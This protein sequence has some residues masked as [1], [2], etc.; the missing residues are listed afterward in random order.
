MSG[1]S[2]EI[3]VVGAG[4]VGLSTAYALVEQGV[5]IRLFEAARPGAGQSAGR[6]R[7]FRHVHRRSELVRRAAESRA[8]WEEWQKRLGVPLLGRQGVMVTGAHA[9]EL[10][11]LL[12]GEGLPAR[13]LDSAE[14]ERLLPIL[15]A[16][17][18]PAV[19]DELAGPS[20]VRAAIDALAA[21]LGERLI[22]GQVFRVEPGA[23]AVLESSEGIWTA[24]RVVLCAGTGIAELAPAAGLELP[25]TIGCHARATFRLRDPAL[26]GRL[27]CL[28]EQSGAYGEIIYSAPVPG[29][30][31]YAVGLAGEDNE[32]PLDADRDGGVARLVS[33]IAAYVEEALPGLDPDPAEVRLCLATTLPEGND[34]F[35]IAQNG[36]VLALAGDNLFKFAPLL[37]RELA[38]AALA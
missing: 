12:A 11:A 35:R 20:H 8:I 10:E 15:R 7:I 29:E 9:P 17:G 13:L 31:L 22:A 33:R 23:P 18:S 2:A 30:P 38:A 1:R 26:A 21:A 19:L 34:A 3:A 28:Q 16:P 14:Q 32:V 37:G 25:L 4:I 5:D 6:T 24:Q 27:P 36:S